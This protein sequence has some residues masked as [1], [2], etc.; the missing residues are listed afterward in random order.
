MILS[1][2]LPDVI[3]VCSHLVLGV[4]LTGVLAMNLDVSSD[5]IHYAKTIHNT[6]SEHTLSVLP[7]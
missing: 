6:R 5:Q 3:K 7:T 1:S 4:L 2:T